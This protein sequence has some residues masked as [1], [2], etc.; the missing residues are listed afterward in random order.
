MKQFRDLEDRRKKTIAICA[1]SARM[2]QK[3]YP[4]IVE[5]YFVREMFVREI[6]DKYDFVNVLNLSGEN[7]HKIAISV[8]RYA[9]GGMKGG[10][11]V[12]GFKG[13]ADRDKLSEI[14]RKRSLKNL[15]DWVKMNDG[16]TGF[17]LISGVERTEVQKRAIEGRGRVPMSGGEL[18]LAYDI[19]RKI[20]YQEKR[21]V[22][23]K[24]VAEKVNKEL[25]GGKNIRTSKAVK[26]MVYR[27]KKNLKTN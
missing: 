11:Y 23:W 20:E 15:E 7:A 26:C 5:D 2:L 22:C 6:V 9:L 1:N 8:V 13:L 16:K 14:G 10:R 27:Y 17:A 25:Y 3:N 12:R 24:R 19:S 18:K 21:G 4:Q